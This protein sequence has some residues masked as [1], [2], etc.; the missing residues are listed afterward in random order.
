MLSNTME[1]LFTKR[2]KIGVTG[3]S[4]AGKTLFI[5]SLAQALLSTNVWKNKRGQGPLAHFAPVERGS[6]RSAH[7]RNDI[8]SHLPQFPFI[9][10][11]NSLVEQDAIDVTQPLEGVLIL[12]EDA[13][14]SRPRQADGNGHRRRQA[15]GT[16]T[17]DHQEGH[18]L[19]QGVD[20]LERDRP[21]APDTAGPSIPVH[22]MPRDSRS[23]H[24]RLLLRGLR[25]SWQR[26]ARP[27]GTLPGSPSAEMFRAAAARGS[28]RSC[29]S[30]PTP[31]GRRRRCVGRSP[32]VAARRGCPE[33]RRAGR[34]P[35]LCSGLDSQ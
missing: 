32:P 21:T 25:P 34:L 35:T 4:R 6:F 12:D 2:I 23:R 15:Q 29:R 24:L 27:R 31:I 22:P 17:G 3:F 30:C 20:S 1:S 5:S 14:A 11:R 16:G 19:L 13:R 18:R 7:I 8:N 10:V 33:H 28:P 9:K 26:T